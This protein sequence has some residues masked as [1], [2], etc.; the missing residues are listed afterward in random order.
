VFSIVSNFTR[1]QLSRAAP[2]IRHRVLTSPALV[3]IICDLI[4]HWAWILLH[5]GC[6]SHLRNRRSFRALVLM[7][8]F[9]LECFEPEW[10]QSNLS[11]RWWRLQFWILQPKLLLVESVW[12]G[13]ANE[14][15]R[16]CDDKTKQAKLSQVLA[17]CNRNGIHSVF[18]NKEDPSD[19][20]T[21]LP[22]AKLFKNIL[23]TDRA[24][25]EIYRNAGEFENVGVL[26]FAAQPRLH[27]PISR[28][29]FAKTFAFAG[30]LYPTK[31]PK[32]T[33]WI[34]SVMDALD[35]YHVDVYDRFFGHPKNSFG[36]L[37][38]G[39]WVKGKLSY[40]DT[41]R[42][43]KSH[44]YCLN[45]NSIE[46]SQ[47]M[48]ARRL[49]EIAACGSLPISSPSPSLKGF[50]DGRVVE[51]K[52]GTELKSK[53][54]NILN[55][56]YWRRTVHLLMRAVLNQHTYS[57]RVSQILEMIGVHHRPK[58]CHLGYW[59]V[60]RNEQ[61]FLKLKNTIVQQSG[62]DAHFK[63]FSEDELRRRG[64]HQSN[65]YS[66]AFNELAHLTR[67]NTGPDAWVEISHQ[68]TYGENYSADI[69]LALTYFTGPFLGKACIHRIENGVSR[70]VDLD[71]THQMV[72][73]IWPGTLV[74]RSNALKRGSS[75]VF[76]FADPSGT[77]VKF[78]RGASA[79]STDPF[80]VLLGEYTSSDNVNGWSV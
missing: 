20:Q 55:E 65:I 2:L 64:R 67:G 58:K 71:Q 13:R 14:W 30:G 26:C 44:S 35:S 49:F 28:S 32:R 39:K 66:N 27:N 7:D 46:N 57:H 18:W 25:V 21:F 68:L 6:Q 61:E 47:T 53:I 51:V 38:I 63:L 12:R 79:L 16:L 59:G 62:A 41:V 48:C 60:Y 8:E 33:E 15:I 75:A 1:T 52:D 56:E 54:P 17:Y 42:A 10:I 34:R 37:G 19:F 70:I 73:S 24:C 4:K 77:K 50:F 29:A 72:T 69:C 31:F 23:T 22:V 76:E 80:N 43:Y 5:N 40:L 3:W 9:S 45:V 78:G 74:V 36:A 11:F